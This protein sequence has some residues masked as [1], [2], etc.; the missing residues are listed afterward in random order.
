MVGSPN[1]EPSFSSRQHSKHFFASGPLS[2]HDSEDD[3][4]DDYDDEG[5]SLKEA[6]SKV[7]RNNE[8]STKNISNNNSSKN[9]NVISN[10]ANIISPSVI[11]SL[12]GVVQDDEDDT[13][14]DVSSYQTHQQ[15]KAQ[16]EFRDNL[17]D[18]VRTFCCYTFRS[19]KELTILFICFVVS[20]TIHIC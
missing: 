13:N 9:S 10:S 8:N 4:A 18:Q 16:M 19:L 3:D 12:F 7:N 14:N 5:V 2:E 15:R 20:L 17:Y 6:P 1:G 11:S